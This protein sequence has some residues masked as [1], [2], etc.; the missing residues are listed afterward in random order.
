MGKTNNLI[1][2]SLI[3]FPQREWDFQVDWHIG[4]FYLKGT[5][6]LCNIL[7]QSTTEGVDIYVEMSSCLIHGELV[8]LI[9]KLYCWIVQNLNP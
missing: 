4:Q 2:Y 7:V 5:H 8:Q 6:P 1:F 9:D 3:G